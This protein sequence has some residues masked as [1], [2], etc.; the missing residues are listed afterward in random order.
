[1]H[2]PYWGRIPAGI[3]SA[4][5]SEEALTILEEH[6]LMTF[7]NFLHKTYTWMSEQ[8]YISYLY[9]KYKDKFAIG[10]VKSDQYLDIEHSDDSKIWTVIYDKNKSLKYLHEKHK[11]LKEYGFQDHI[12]PMEAARC[13]QS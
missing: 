10:M 7:D 8:L 2:D 1:M 6:S 11:L 4:V 3:K 12:D 9:D 13:S 5:K